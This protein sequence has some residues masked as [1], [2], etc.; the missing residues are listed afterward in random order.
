MLYVSIVVDYDADLVVFL[1]FSVLF[2]FFYDAKNEK[3]N[4]IC[5]CCV[6]HRV[7]FISMCRVT[8][9]SV[10]VLEY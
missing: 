9:Y 2:G 7:L 6:I 3:E 10:V 8:I 4:V 5:C 1:F